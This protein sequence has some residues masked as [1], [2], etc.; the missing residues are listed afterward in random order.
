MRSIALHFHT[1]LA[2]LATNIGKSSSHR[3]TEHTQQLS[4]TVCD[5]SSSHS[6]ECDYDR[7]L[8]TA[9]PAT[10]IL[11]ACGLAILETNIT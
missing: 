3:I 6:G 1:S 11:K 8:G 10:A 5:I 7:L 2:L 9:P 4:K